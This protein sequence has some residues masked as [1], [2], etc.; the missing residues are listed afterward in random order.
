MGQFDASRGQQQPEALHTRPP[1]GRDLRAGDIVQIRS[2]QEILATLDGDGSLAA[3]PF[4]PEM[5]E[6]CGRTFTVDK[7]ADKACDTIEWSGLRRMDD[8]VHLAG[9]RCDGSAHGGCEA[10]CLIFW[11]EAWLKQPDTEAAKPATQE[12]PPLTRNGGSPPWSPAGA[13]GVP[14]VLSTATR[15]ATMG[16]GADEERYR[17]QATE[18]FRA[19]APLPWWDV[20][21]YVRDVRSGNVGLAVLVRGLLVAV[22]NKLQDLNR[23][24][25]PRLLLVRGG[26]SYPFVT[27]SLQRTPRDN[28]NLQPGDL[29]EV[30]SREEILATLDKDGRNRGMSFDSEMLRYCGRRARVLR[31]VERII[32]ENTGKMMHLHT[33]CIILEG[34][35]CVGAYRRFCPRSIYPYWREIWLK[36]AAG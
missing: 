1:P 36:R 20:R 4:M 35:V 25:L 18:L 16:E 15:V 14:E 32:N 7:R 10:G 17:C 30:K 34:V 3:L 33:D 11:K 28:L 9:L 19:T 21:Q 27:G 12:Q 29:V 13:V 2:A 26:R 23:R 31:R 5:L 6:F 22:F 24:L 8:A